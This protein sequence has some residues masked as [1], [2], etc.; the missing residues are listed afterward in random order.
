MIPC[1]FCFANSILLT[2]PNISALILPEI[3]MRDLF[4]TLRYFTVLTVLTLQF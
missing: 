1:D 3:T 4:Y 2:A